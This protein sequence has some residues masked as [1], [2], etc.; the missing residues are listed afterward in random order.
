MILN[1]ENDIRIKFSFDELKKII[2]VFSI[3]TYD[4]ETTR[5]L[6][7]DLQNIMLRAQKE[8]DE[9]KEKTKTIPTEEDVLKVNNL[10]SEMLKKED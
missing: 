5:K 1:S 9:K 8:F 3:T 2:E 6:K 4:D 10:S 7:D